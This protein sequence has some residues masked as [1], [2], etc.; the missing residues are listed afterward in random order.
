MSIP[1]RIRS[2]DT[3][4]WGLV[5]LD[6]VL[7][8]AMA[9]W[10]ITPANL[11]LVIIA[12]AWLLLSLLGATIALTIR[13][14]RHFASWPLWLA[15]LALWGIATLAVMRVINIPHIGLSFLGS[16]VFLYSGISLFIAFCMRMY[17]RDSGLSLIGWITVL[18]IWSSLFTWI[19]QG[20]L[21]D[22]FFLSMERPDQPSSVWGLSM[23]FS[24]ACCLIPIAL[25][26]FA[27]HTLVL[28]RREQ[29]C[30]MPPCER[31][32]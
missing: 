26:S 6:I 27:W 7:I 9:E 11:G 22:A 14:R 32:S 28:L 4:L 12:L 10:Q 29:K 23:L 25:V 21:L 18:C 8:F 17:L 2:V 20:D 24:G 13:Y 19:A 31:A 30:K 1:L 3:C 16:M 15:L 5:A